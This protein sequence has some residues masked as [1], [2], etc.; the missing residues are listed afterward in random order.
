MALAAVAAA[1]TAGLLWPQMEDTDPSG[2]QDWELV[3]G[4]PAGTGGGGQAIGSGLPVHSR[5][6]LYNKRTGK[7]YRYFENC[8]SGGVEEDGGCFYMIRVLDQRNGFQ[9]RVQPTDASSGSVR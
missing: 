4:Y 7:V 1:A 6:F 2:V 8:T 9:V 3:P 5:M